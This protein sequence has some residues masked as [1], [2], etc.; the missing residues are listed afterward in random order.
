MSLK[1]WRRWGSSGNGI[2]YFFHTNSAHIFER[3]YATSVT[4]C[5][6]IVVFSRWLRCYLGGA[7]DVGQ[8]D[9]CRQYDGS[10]LYGFESTFLLILSGLC[11]VAL[12][13]GMMGMSDYGHFVLMLIQ[14]IRQDISKF[15]VIYMVCLV[16]FSHMLNIVRDKQNTGLEGF[17]NSVKSIFSASLEKLELPEG[18]NENSGSLLDASISGWHF[19]TFLVYF[20]VFLNF[21]FVS[22]V[23]INLLIAMMSSTYESINKRA[24]SGWNHCR[25]SIITNLDKELDAETRKRKENCYWELDPS[26]SGLKWKR[27]A[28][29]CGY[30]NDTQLNY[31][32]ITNNN[33]TKWKRTAQPPANGRL[34]RHRSLFCRKK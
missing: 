10:W 21:F 20:I 22:L 12:F 1:E 18:T 23:L 32:I 28:Q 30:N 9:T 26:A 6:F 31:L 16:W 34:L 14:M 2:D 13:R 29:V 4:P 7:L 11:F 3:T 17:W 25:A 33:N 15:V 24:K 5:A 27:A 19:T 8:V